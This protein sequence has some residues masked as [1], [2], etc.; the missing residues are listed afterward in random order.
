MAT[1]EASQVGELLAWQSQFRSSVL[2][3]ETSTPPSAAH[4]GGGGV[5]GTADESSPC[6]WLDCVVG[7]SLCSTKFC[8]LVS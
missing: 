8:L 2:Q 4:V 1:A 7:L 3:R 6:S 5:T